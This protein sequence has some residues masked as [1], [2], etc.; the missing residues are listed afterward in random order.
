M[1]IGTHYYGEKILL[2]PEITCCSVWSELTVKKWELKNLY[3]GKLSQ[4][5]CNMLIISDFI[6]R[7]IES[8]WRYLQ[9]EIT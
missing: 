8:N 7:E 2:I 3:P 6:P 5:L 9:W 4:G 1:Q